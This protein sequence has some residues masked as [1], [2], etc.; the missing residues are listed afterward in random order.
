M[1]TKLILSLISITL[2]FIVFSNTNLIDKKIELL[3]KAAMNIVKCS[4]TNFLLSDIDST[5]QI[6][7]LFENLGSH[8]FT[9]STNNNKSQ[10]YFNQGLNLAYAFNHPESHRS[11]MEA[12]RLDPNAAMTYWG[13]AYVLG[14]NINDQL[15]DAER[16]LKSFEAVQKAK[17][18][19]SKSTPKE[20]ALI[21]ALTHRYSKDSVD[22]TKLNMAYMKAMEKV[23][24]KYP[25]DADIQTLYTAA[26]MNTVPWNYWDKDGNPSPNI[27]EA[28]LALEKAME[29]NINHPGANHYYIHMVELPKPDLAV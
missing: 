5:K 17:K 11:F 28:K 3:P 15:P 29:I 7:P 22:I 27:K 2:L 1:K 20:Q 6:S 21:E 4:S 16:R 26:V 24:K 23:V 19:A 9:I 25:Q 13:Q 14:P 18:L 10:I 8:V 12:S